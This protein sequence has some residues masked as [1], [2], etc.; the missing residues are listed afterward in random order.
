MEEIVKK[1]SLSIL[2][3]FVIASFTFAQTITVKLPHAGDIWYKGHTYNITW[4]K[5]GNAGVNVKINIFRNSIIP[6]NFVEQLTGPNSGSKSWPIPSTYDNGTYYIRIKGV[7][8]SWNDVGVYGDSGAFT[9]TDPPAAATITVTSPHSG[10]N[11]CKGST[12][13]ITWT[14]TSIPAS[15]NIKINI[16]KDSIKQAN[17]KL[18][19]TCTNTSLKSW[20][21]STNFENGT[22]YIRVKTE[23]NVVHGDSGGFIITKE[24]G[25]P[26]FELT[27][28]TTKG[29][30][31][32]DK[33][34]A[35]GVM[36]KNNGDPYDGPLSFRVIGMDK[37]MGGKFTLDRRRNFN[38][39]LAKGEIIEK[40]ILYNISWP[41]D[42]CN[43]SF[44]II[45]DPDNQIPESNEKNN[46]ID[47][48]KYKGELLGKKYC[49]IRILPKII[50]IGKAA[51][52][53]VHDGGSTILAHDKVDIFLTF[54]NSCSETKTL[55][56]SI[57]YDWAPLFKDGENKVIW[58]SK[59]TLRSCEVKPVRISRISIPKKKEFKDLVLRSLH[60]Y[61][62]Q[63]GYDILYK[64]KV[65]VDY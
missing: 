5:T 19:L 20:T 50:K 56:F 57:V 14:S 59:I 17:S 37:L 23:D 15:T 9:I 63:G 22:Y 24:K 3:L 60:Y 53:S 16:F 35:I 65:R 13:N 28:I 40:T 1:L 52:R 48:T 39:R 58:E 38:L 46:V 30:Y 6:A 10:D 41:I 36:I 45:V 11:W 43:V 47:R 27:G 51:L 42:V 4:T 55:D 8:S 34:H 62:G 61:G 25:I 2:G 7:D 29:T 64:I 44:G 18:Q 12:H 26:D 54:R 49:D 21:I 33:I 31:S 32:S